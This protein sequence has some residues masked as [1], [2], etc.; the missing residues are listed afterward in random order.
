MRYNTHVYRREMNESFYT[1][2]TNCR[3]SADYK[4]GQ[5]SKSRSVAFGRAGLI[6]GALPFPEKG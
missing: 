1:C 3:Q 4:T 5:S 6:I 2:H